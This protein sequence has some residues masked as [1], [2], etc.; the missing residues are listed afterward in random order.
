MEYLAYFAL[1]AAFIVF[2]VSYI[3]FGRKGV[4]FSAKV[5][6]QIG[7]LSFTKKN[8]GKSKVRV[9]NL[10]S[11]TE[12]MVGLEWIVPGDSTYIKA[13]KEEIRELIELLNKAVKK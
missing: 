9:F 4:F 2:V 3:K 7:E 6:D 10:E 12:N 11:S 5:K 13:T 1:A 8:T